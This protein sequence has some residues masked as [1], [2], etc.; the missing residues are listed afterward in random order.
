VLEEW[1]ITSLPCDV[2]WAVVSRLRTR[3]K[4]YICRLYVLRSCV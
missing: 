1:R 3:Y 4:V 2:H